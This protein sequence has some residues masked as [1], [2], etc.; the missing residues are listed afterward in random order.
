VRSV[1]EPAQGMLHVGGHRRRSCRSKRGNI[2]CARARRLSVGVLTSP[3]RRIRRAR[4][5]RALEIV[6]IKLRARHPGAAGAPGVRGS[7]YS[8]STF[9]M[10]GEVAPSGVRSNSLSLVVV[11]TVPPPGPRFMCYGCGNRG[12]GQHEK[13]NQQ[14]DDLHF[15]SPFF[16][17]PR[18]ASV[19][20]R[21]PHSTNSGHGTMVD[22]TVFIAIASATACPIPCSLNG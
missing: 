18:K 15:L 5:R 4:P 7:F 21:R 8:T 10:G 14:R 2:D 6:R 12:P 19:R 13:K 20:L 17:T 3:S 16:V 9:R 22:F 11:R 1:S